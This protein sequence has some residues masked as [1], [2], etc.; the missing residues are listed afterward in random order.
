MTTKIYYRR[1]K[2]YLLRLVIQAAKK[3]CYLKLLKDCL[4]TPGH[5][6]P[7]DNLGEAETLAIIVC[8]Y[9]PG[10]TVLFVSDDKDAIALAQKQDEIRGTFGTSRLLELLENKRLISSQESIQ[11]VEKLK[12][13]GR[14]II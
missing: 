1:Y 4:D 14:Y 2:R 12:K 10:E 6:A 13:H 7:A 8:R 11:I 5:C 3:S 9:T